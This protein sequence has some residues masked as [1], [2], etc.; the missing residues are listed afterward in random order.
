MGVFVQGE[1][2][3]ELQCFP[4][5]DNMLGQGRVDPFSTFATQTTPRENYFIRSLYVHVSNQ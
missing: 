5:V 4:P 2:V 1:D 3:D